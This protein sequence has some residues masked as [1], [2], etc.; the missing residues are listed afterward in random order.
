MLNSHACVIVS[1]VPPLWGQSS[2][3]KSTLKE[4]RLTSNLAT[5]TT[6]N[7]LAAQRKKRRIAC[8]EN[9]TFHLYFLS[10]FFT[11]QHL[12]PSWLRIPPSQMRVK[13]WL[14]SDCETILSLDRITDVIVT[15]LKQ[16]TKVLAKVFLARRLEK[17]AVK[18][19]ETVTNRTCFS[20]RHT[21][22]QLFRN[23]LLML[24]R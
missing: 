13:R 10:S 23:K 7:C 8:R 17:M 4:K 21:T 14:E 18:T 20:F 16:H 5:I 19:R 24:L 12:W 11:V 15:L 9:K 6:N 2:S 3:Y 1:T 22:T